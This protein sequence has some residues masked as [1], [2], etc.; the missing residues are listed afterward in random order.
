MILLFNFTPQKTSLMIKR[1]FHRRN[2][3]HLYY[4][5]GI[6]FVT[7]RPYGSILPNELKKLRELNQS[8]EIVT[9]QEQKK[10]FKRYD[11]LLDKPRNEIQ[12]LSQP[13]ILAICKSSLHFYDGREYKLICYCIM[14]N[15]IHLVFELLNKERNIGNIMGSV[16]KFIARESNKILGRKG[17]FWQSESFDTLIRDDVDLYFIIKYVLMNPVSAGLVESWNDWRGTYCRPEYEVID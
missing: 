3:P 4:N 2:L 7:F 5:E 16:K 11:S 14:P 8:N 6:Y 12:Y 1:H 15:H 10:I 9:A 13:E 17:T